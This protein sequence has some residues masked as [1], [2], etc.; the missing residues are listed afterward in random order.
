MSMPNMDKP[1]SAVAPKT[2]NGRVLIGAM[3]Y[4]VPMQQVENK[5]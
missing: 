3:K 4:I 5:S 1:R 2:S